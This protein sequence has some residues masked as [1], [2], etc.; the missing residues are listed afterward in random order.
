MLIAVANLPLLSAAEARD[1]LRS[2]AEELTRQMRRL[3]T[4]PSAQPPAPAFVA[5]IFDHALASLQA[6]LD[7][8]HRTIT[9]LEDDAAWT[10]P[11]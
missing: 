10:R 8:T 4:Q 11:I 1:G 2:R 3:Q 7:W 9:T 5:A 6:E